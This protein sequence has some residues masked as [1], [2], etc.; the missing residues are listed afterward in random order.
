MMNVNQ[1]IPSLP[2]LVKNNFALR[3][4]WLLSRRPWRAEIILCL[5][6]GYHVG[7][8][9]LRKLIIRNQ[10]LLGRPIDI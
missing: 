4:R 2:G 3:A 1:T 5:V 8:G 7:L 6:P 10:R 9:L